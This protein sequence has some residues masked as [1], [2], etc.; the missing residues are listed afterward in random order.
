MMRFNK[1]INEVEYCDGTKWLTLHSALQPASSCKQIAFKFKSSSNNGQ[2]WIKP[3][4]NDP[5]FQVG[6]NPIISDN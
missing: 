6:N 2:Y 5:P 4:A 3:T 1:T